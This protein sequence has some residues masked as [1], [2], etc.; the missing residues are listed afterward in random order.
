M[1]CEFPFPQKQ[2]SLFFQFDSKL[3]KSEIVLQKTPPPRWTLESKSNLGFTT[4]KK[5]TSDTFH[6]LSWLFKRHPYNDW[7][8]KNLHVTKGSSSSP[9]YTQN[10]Q[11]P[12][13]SLLRWGSSSQ[14]NWRVH[15]PPS[16]PPPK[17]DQPPWFRSIW[18]WGVGPGG[19]LI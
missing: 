12:I 14:G 7:L 8:M 10:S 1:W 2:W 9:T 13:F 17:G 16:N 11:G 15:T 4:N 5:N 6:E 19:P 18:H 3:R